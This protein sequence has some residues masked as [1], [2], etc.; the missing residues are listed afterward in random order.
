MSVAHEFWI[1]EIILW[2]I[3]V[4]VLGLTSL[5][6]YLI[7]RKDKTPYKLGVALFLFL[8]LIAR[9]CVSLLV[10]VYLYDGVDQYLINEPTKLW[11]QL[12]YNL[13][14]Y[15]GICILYFVLERYIIKTKYIFS[16][17]TII[18][19]TLSIVNYF[20]QE[21]LFLYQV[22]FFLP[23]VLG[24]PVMYFYL[25]A[26]SS[27]EVRKNSLLIAVGMI[28]FELG[29][30]FAIPNAQA[31]ILAFMDPVIYEF[32]GPIL[33]IISLV[34]LYFGFSRSVEQ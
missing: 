12:G 28:L 18:L 25:A 34:I 30:V 33:H 2:I 7:H 5:G 31:T 14:S 17:L 8:S 29:V 13:F 23:V 24:F 27:G 3:V 1:I 6:I 26:T 4:V 21:N 11:L 10:Y 20:V 9:I 19:L 32:L 22:P 15:S 16:A